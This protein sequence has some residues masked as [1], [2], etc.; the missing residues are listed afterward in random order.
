MR[1]AVANGAD[2]VYLGGPGFNARMQAANFSQEELEAAVKYA[3]HR[4]VKVYVTV[5]T[6][7]L[8]EEL[9]PAVDY[10]H[11][12]YSL[13]VDGVL[14]QDLGL[15]AVLR[16]WLPQL[17]VH[18]STQMT[19][20]NPAGVRWLADRGVKRVVLARELSL[21]DITA[22][23]RAVP[24]VE[25][26]IFVHGALCFAYSGQCLFSSLVGGRSGNRGW[27]A[28]PCR[29]AY[30]LLATE[31]REEV[32]GGHLL[33]TRDLQLLEY[34]PQVAA[35]GVA[36][37][38]IEGR[39]KRP[40]YV[41]VVTR[42]YRQALDR[43]RRD[44]DH[45]VVTAEENRILAQ[46]FNRGFTTG[47]LLDNPGRDLMSYQRP[48]NRGVY[49]GRVTG[50]DA[51]R[52][53]ARVEV[54]TAVLAVGDGVAFWVKHGVVGSRIAA[55]LLQG[56]PV[57]RV[58]PPARVEIPVP[59]EVH[60]GD[61]IFKTADARLLEEAR[62]SYTQPAAGQRVALRIVLEGGPGRVLC[63]TGEDGLGQR[64]AV[65]GS[66]PGEVAVQH[67]LTP[68]VAAAQ[69]GR[70]GGTPYYLAGLTCQLS[71]PVMYPL[72]ELNTV[73]RALVEKLLAESDRRS[74]RPA[75]PHSKGEDRLA[76]V[77]PARPELR[78][79]APRERHLPRLAVA[80]SHPI[81]ARAALEAEADRIYFAAEHFRSGGSFRQQEVE[82]VCRAAR[83][84]GQ[85]F[86]YALP[87]IWRQGQEK[88][89]R[90]LPKMDG[91]WATDGI[92]LAN[93]AG[94]VLAAQAGLPGPLY[95][96]Y[97]LNVTN[98]QAVD[99]LREQGLQKVTFS[100]ELNFQQLA[101]LA[102][103]STLPWEVVV[104]GRLPLMISEHCVPG[105]VAGNRAGG[106]PCR[107]PCTGQTFALRDRRRFIFPLETD[108]YCRMHLFN[109]HVLCLVEELPRL[110]ALGADTI[111]I[112]ARQGDPTCIAAVTRVYRQV[113]E[114]LAAGE[115]VSSRELAA[116]RERL[117]AISPGGITKGYFWR[118]SSD[119]DFNL[120]L[121]ER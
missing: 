49:L 16:R 52:R 42:I 104:H 25:L 69:L 75:L 117:A 12:L 88:A 79:E 27:C 90:W 31:A 19:I 35:A 64:A 46:I 82:E 21:E 72:R 14:V 9:L 55:I 73:R 67:P 86:V 23:H 89:L 121:Q 113:L 38:K 28:Q 2:A 107:R 53:L 44:P 11:Y 34:L 24:E 102:A 66:I 20:H 29:L 10:L 50:V 1:A 4:G 116:Y 92:M 8:P 13:G 18:A 93:P 33:S 91:S 95:G 54:E 105:A 120:Q 41:A 106:R 108:Q 81:A 15:L 98:S 51:S 7:V 100:V 97:F 76:V 43:L 111:R 59:P 3:H 61:R 87:R 47:Y 101:D 40:E 65:Q 70:L 96:D 26:E 56:K 22:I 115:L 6:L 30:T 85:E 110:A 114:R 99:L 17:P 63:V 78:W 62:R 32:A 77:A 80:V 57:E 36:A 45:Y 74:A 84:R 37:L 109:A 68:E 83:D 5:N 48:N 71:E 94:L 39:M 103:A 112:E 119:Q 118:A 60:A 58:E